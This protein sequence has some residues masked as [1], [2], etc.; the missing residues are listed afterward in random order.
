[1]AATTSAATLLEQRK[2]SL[3][4]LVALARQ[5]LERL[6][7]GHHLLAANN[8]TVL[9]LH[10]IRLGETTGCV[11]GRSVKHLGLGS[12]CGHVIGHLIHWNAILLRRR[13]LSAQ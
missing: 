5:V 12:N 7:A 4:R 1:V 10:K 6:L 9:V 2:V 3:A 13:S 8:P 11:L